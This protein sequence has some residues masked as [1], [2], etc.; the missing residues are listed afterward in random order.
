LDRIQNKLQEFLSPQDAWETVIE[1]Y[2][3]VLEADDEIDRILRDPLV[4]KFYEYDGR[5]FSRKSNW[6]FYRAFDGIHIL[7]SLNDAILET[8]FRS[9]DRYFTI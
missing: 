7:Q 3:L 2:D 5:F 9:R 1:I 8:F 4:Q 6:G